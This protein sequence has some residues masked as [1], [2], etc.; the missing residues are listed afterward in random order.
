MVFCQYYS[1]PRFTHCLLLIQIFH[2]LSNNANLKITFKVN[3]TN[4]LIGYN[5]SDYINLVNSQK[6]TNKYK[7]ILSS[8]VF[9]H[10]S[11]F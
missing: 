10:L 4:K 2:S 1:N 3:F 7:I 6:S 9:S 11:N 8:R 5:D